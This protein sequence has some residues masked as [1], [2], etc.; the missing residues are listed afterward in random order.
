MQDADNIDAI[1]AI[2]I[3]RTWK[4]SGA[5]NTPIWIPGES[6]DVHGNYQE[7]G[8][9]TSI[10]RH[11][12]EKLLQLADHM[13]TQTARIIALE[14]NKFMQLYLEQFFAEWR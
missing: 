5:H 11:F 12:Y 7:T 1:G 14:R 4:Y 6:L 2:G 9:D 8:K 13:N 10:I 3:A